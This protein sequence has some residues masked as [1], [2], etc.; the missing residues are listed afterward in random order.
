MS[1]SRKLIIAATGAAGGVGKSTLV[2]LLAETYRRAGTVPVPVIVV[3]DDKGKKDD[4]VT[5]AELLPDHTVIWIGAG[6]RQ[7]DVEANIDVLSEHFDRLDATLK[8]HSVILDCGANVLARVI[9][10]MEKMNAGARWKKRGIEMEIWAPFNN[11]GDNIACAL[12]TFRA[13][14]K[15]GAKVIGVRNLKDGAFTDFETSV[16]GAMIKAL[17]DKGGALIDLPK[18]G[19]PPAGMEAALKAN[20]NFFTVADMDEDAAAEDLGV[21]EQVAVRTIVGVGKWIDAFYSNAGAL[22]PSRA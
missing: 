9:D 22:I 11:V 21:S 7:E 16:D 19:A 10:Y 4:I 13:G 5:A 20:L 17:V 14:A 3:A 6:P 8:T 12:D 18:C 2:Q 15:I 1:A